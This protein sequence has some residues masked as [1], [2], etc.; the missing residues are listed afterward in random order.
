MFSCQELN[1]RLSL[2]VRLDVRI[3]VDYTCMNKPLQYL[4]STNNGS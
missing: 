2:G 3:K 1:P 4:H